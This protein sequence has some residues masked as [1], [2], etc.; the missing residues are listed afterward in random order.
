FD[1]CSGQTPFSGADV[2]EVLQKVV[3]TEAPPVD[4]FAPHVPPEVAGVLKRGLAKDPAARY[5]NVLDLAIAL[6]TAC[7]CSL[8]PPQPFVDALGTP[9]TM[10][11]SATAPS[12][13]RAPPA[14]LQLGER[15]Q[16]ASQRRA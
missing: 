10:P 14:R 16:T 13:S 2:M 9:S 15:S 11:T 4:R 3:S 7:E 1:M 12:A 6:S 5:D 8:P